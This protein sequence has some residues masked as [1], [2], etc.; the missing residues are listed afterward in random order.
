MEGCLNPSGTNE[1]VVM[2]VALRCLELEIIPKLKNIE[3]EQKKMVIGNVVYFHK[4][5]TYKVR[6]VSVFKPEM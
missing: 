4:N 6:P 5:I 1:N 3:H 2:T